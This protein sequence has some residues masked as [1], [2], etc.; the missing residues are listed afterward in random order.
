ME[1]SG[2]FDLLYDPEK[3]KEFQKQVQPGA[4]TADWWQITAEMKL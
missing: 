4:P 3:R 2:Q 1:N